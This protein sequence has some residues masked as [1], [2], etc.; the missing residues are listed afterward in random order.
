MK[1]RPQ[2]A[3]QAFSPAKAVDN[4]QINA[5]GNSLHDRWLCIG[6]ASLIKAAALSAC[7]AI[8]PYVER[9]LRSQIDDVDRGG[10]IA[11]ALTGRNLNEATEPQSVTRGFRTHVDKKPI[12]VKTPRVVDRCQSR[13]HTMIPCRIFQ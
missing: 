1:A 9:F 8:L 13:E 5:I 4:Q 7:S 11:A 12:D 2:P 10:T 6:K 3:P